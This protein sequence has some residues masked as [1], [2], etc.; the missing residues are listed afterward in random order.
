MDLELLPNENCAE[1][2]IYL[3]TDS[4]LCAGDMEGGKD[5]CVVSGL[6]PAMWG[7]ADRGTSE[8]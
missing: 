8:S 1:A 5:T 4:M 2:H 3:V 6:L 7:R